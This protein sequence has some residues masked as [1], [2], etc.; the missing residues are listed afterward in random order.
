MLDPSWERATG[1]ELVEA[2]LKNEFVE[3]SEKTLT[4]DERSGR[5][6]I[7]YSTISLTHVII[8]LKRAE[9][10]CKLGELIDQGEK[11]YS[12]LKKLLEDRGITNQPIDIVFLLGK[13][14]KGWEDKEKKHKGIR[15]LKEQNMRVLLYKELITNARRVYKEYLVKRKET[16]R[17]QQILDG[18]DSDL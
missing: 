1:T 9:R 17:I 15:T 12:T 5:V 3:A 10:H 13:A 2:N 4:K 6:D 8:E 16:G 14:P 18:I 11:Y 7:K